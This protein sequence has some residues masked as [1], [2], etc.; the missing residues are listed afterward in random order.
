MKLVDNNATYADVA[1]KMID[2]AKTDGHPDYATFIEKHFTLRE[3]LGPQAFAGHPD[4][5]HLGIYAN[6]Y[7]CCGT[8]QHPEYQT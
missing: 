7:G 4:L 8:M 1:K 2:I 5:S 3:V 6:R